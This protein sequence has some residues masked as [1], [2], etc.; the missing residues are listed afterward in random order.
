MTDQPAPDPVVVRLS[1]RQRVV[2]LVVAIFVLAAA[3]SLIFGPGRG[4]R[5]DLH[6]V[7]TDVAETVRIGHTTL[8]RLE[9]QL[10]KTQRSLRV[11][12]Q[13]LRV[14]RDTQAITATGVRSAENIEQQT[15]QAVAM[16]RR[17]ITALGPLQRLQGDI[18]TVVDGVEAGVVLARSALDVARTTLDDGK[19][20][21]AIAEETLRTLSRSEQIQI[22]LLRTARAT[23]QE[24]T[25]INSK[26]PFPPIAPT[27]SR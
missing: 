16:L 3:C 4:A 15:V 14:V 21:L 13:S 17:V 1:G 12:Q 23:L 8:A 7:R 27:S 6:Q 5:E 25:E 2:A 22:Q 11:Q 18:D 20:A 26:I 9:S 10:R 19:R 24:T